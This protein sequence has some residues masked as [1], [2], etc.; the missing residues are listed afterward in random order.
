MGSKKL[1]ILYY[2]G[3]WPTNIG[4]AFIDIGATNLLS[5]TNVSA[6]IAIASQYSK[7]MMSTHNKSGRWGVDLAEM[8]TPDVLVVAGMNLCQEFVD[9]QGPVLK[10]LSDNKV[11]ILF[12]GCG[13]S[14][15]N[16]KEKST[17]R[18]FLSGLDNKLAFISRDHD[19]YRLY[20][21]LFD[22]SYDGID[23]GFFLALNYKPYRMI[24]EEYDIFNFDTMPEPNILVKNK[25]IRTAHSIV[26]YTQDRERLRESI[27]I[28]IGQKPQIEIPTFNYPN[29]NSR[30]N[31]SAVFFSD[32]PTDYLNLYFNA[33]DIY[34]DRV[35]TAVAGLVFGKRVRFY[36][37]TP[38]AKIFQRFEL[39]GLKK[40]LTTLPKTWL[41]KEQTAQINFLKRTLRKNIE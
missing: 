35:H 16:E 1:N 2:G 32:I 22:A 29:L 40:R 19:S 10:R 31:K 3:G 14:D 4:N 24:S 39:S 9:V 36:S 11:K 21:D 34:T 25:V 30:T 37:P 38:R 7:W 15:Y 23:C 12:C 13:G 41:L 26:D 18:S 28:K 8:S 27:S 33:H 20:C 17:V 5:K 6:N